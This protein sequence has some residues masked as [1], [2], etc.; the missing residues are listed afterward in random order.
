M[1]IERKFLVDRP[2][3]LTSRSSTRIEQGYL[4]LI[5]HG[6]EVRL[7]RRD[8]ELTLTVKGGGGRERTEVELPL[9]GEQFE[10]LWPFTEGRRLVKVRHLV[11]VGGLTAEVDVYEGELE[12][13]RIAEV[14]FESEVEADRF[15]PPEW[16]GDE[17]TGDQRYLN[18]RLAVEGRP[19]V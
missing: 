6:A 3:D 15:N 10:E 12:G 14:E 1:E 4:S 18:E 8:G 5:E 19:G 13:L 16:L 7:R 17:V 11:P 9:T 2:P